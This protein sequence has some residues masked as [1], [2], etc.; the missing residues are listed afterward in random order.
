MDTR[1]TS[2]MYGALAAAGMMVIFGVDAPVMKSVM[3]EWINAF[4]L[5]SLRMLL[6]ASLSLLLALILGSQKVAPKDRKYLILTGLFGILL[7]QGGI[8]IGVQYSSPIDVGLIVTTTPIIV[9]LLSILVKKVKV[10]IG[11]IIGLIIGISGVLLQLFFS[12]ASKDSSHI[13]TF[14][15]NLI[16]FIGII[17]YALYLTFAGNI[18]SKYNLVTLI[19]WIF[20]SAALFS[21]PLGLID[22]IHSK[23]FTE[24]A[25]TNVYL[26]FL[27]S[28]LF[29]TF[30]A[31]LLNMIAMK[32][33]SG[34]L[35]AI[36]GYLQP[37]ITAIIAIALNQASLTLTNI[38]SGILILLGV[39]MATKADKKE[40]S[41]KPT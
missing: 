31:F 27:F 35:I 19:K 6:A 25:P 33:I 20:V 30:I 3:P 26:R 41:A 23:A 22:L 12:G 38:G 11:V 21:L 32:K 34:R 10:N 7:N 16:V 24:V 37:L 29:A 13:N 28:G 5:I 14:T 39:F 8:T 18:L 9:V 17:S 2:K 1:K 36:F 15:G 40:S 4:G